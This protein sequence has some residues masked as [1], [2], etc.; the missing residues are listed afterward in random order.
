MPATGGRVRAVTRGGHAL[1]A[2]SSSP[3]GQT[4]ACIG[5]VAGG[6]SC[7][8]V[9]LWT[10]PAAGGGPVCLTAGVDLSLGSDVISDLRA[11]HPTPTPLWTD[12]GARLRF[13]TSERGNV[14]LYEIDAADGEPR[15]ADRR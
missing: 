11:D 6:P 8:N 14:A 3:D 5:R 10:V 13:L 1:G 4:I 15:R 7:A 12:D 9:R 2:P